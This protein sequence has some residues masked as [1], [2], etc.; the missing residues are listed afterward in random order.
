MDDDGWMTWWFKRNSRITD[1]AFSTEPA[2]IFPPWNEG[3]ISNPHTQEFQ[4]CPVG[5][6]GRRPRQLPVYQNQTEL[7]TLNWAHST[8]TNN[9]T[10]GRS[11]RRC[12]RRALW[13]TITHGTATTTFECDVTSLCVR[14]YFCANPDW[15]LQRA[16]CS[17]FSLFCLLF[18]NISFFFFVIINA[19]FRRFDALIILTLVSTMSPI[20]CIAIIQ[21]CMLILLVWMQRGLQ[22]NMFGLNHRVSH[23][24]CSLCVALW[25]MWKSNV[26]FLCLCS[27]DL[28]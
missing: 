16:N 21:F 24:T 12:K 18:F 6:S 17:Q 8:E 2:V 9:G 3:T 28:A 7:F 13:R 1:E 14:A 11:R 19:T 25:P 27:Q 4:D 10:I 23:I 15:R 20:L 22:W 26:L 5:S